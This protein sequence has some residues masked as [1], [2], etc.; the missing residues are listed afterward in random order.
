[1]KSPPG[2]SDV[3]VSR[4]EEETLSLGRRIGS[5][6][7]PPRVVLLIGDLGSGKTVFARGLCEGLGLRP[8]TVVHSPTFT[9]VN[10]YPSSS[11][12]IYH[13]DLYRLE[14]LRDLYSIGIEDILSQDAVIV[15]EWAEKLQFELENSIHVFIAHQ[16]GIGTRVIRIEP[17]VAE[18]EGAKD[19]GSGAVP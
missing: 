5:R 12:I 3:I 11:G 4:S 13:I 17:G 7:I 2:M 9:L 19:T 1:M 8:G 15:V 18:L 10:E 6:I 16:K 14:T